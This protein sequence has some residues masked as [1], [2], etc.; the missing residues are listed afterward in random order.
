[1]PERVRHQHGRGRPRPHGQQL[2]APGTLRTNERQAHWPCFRRRAP[3]SSVRPCTCSGPQPTRPGRLHFPSGTHSASSSLPHK[4]TL[5][6]GHSPLAQS[7]D[8]QTHL[9][10]P[11]PACPSEFSVFRLC[12]NSETLRWRGPSDH[13]R[14]QQ[15]H[16][17]CVLVTRLVKGLV[18]DHVLGARG[19]FFLKDS[20]SLAWPPPLLYHWVL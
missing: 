20:L 1:M 17:F 19:D 4:A 16:L 9:T 2:W 3:P 7:R 14:S 12:L 6:P 8:L 10:P 13:L 18:L 11:S 15:R 5:L